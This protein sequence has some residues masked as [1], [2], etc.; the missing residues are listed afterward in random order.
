MTVITRK[1]QVG[2]MIA[3]EVV[4]DER[5]SPIAYETNIRLDFFPVFDSF[6]DVEYGEDARDVEE[7]VS[8]SEMGTYIIVNIVIS[9][10]WSPLKNETETTDQ[11]RPIKFEVNICKMQLQYEQLTRLPKPKTHFLG[12]VWTSKPG[13]GT[14]RS[15]SNTNGSGYISLSRVMALVISHY[16]IY[17]VELIQ[18][19]TKYWRPRWFP[20]GS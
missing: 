10:V 9:I 3:T 4:H 11:G 17:I 5:Y 18:I 2:T 12:S 15:G 19:L 20:L 8:F 16:Q 6:G 7:Q 1:G 14:N 13:R